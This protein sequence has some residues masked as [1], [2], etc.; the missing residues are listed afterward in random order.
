[1]NSETALNLQYCLVVVQ[2][3]P[4]GN[5]NLDISA[6]SVFDSC[7]NEITT[8]NA[9]TNQTS[10]CILSEHVRKHSNQNNNML[11]Q[12]MPPLKAKFVQKF[13]NVNFP[14]GVTTCFKRD[15]LIVCD[16]GKDLIKIFDNTAKLLR[17]FQNSNYNDKEKRFFLR[18]PSALLID[19]EN[20][21]LLF[22]KDDTYQCITIG[23]PKLH[24]GFLFSRIQDPNIG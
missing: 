7:L 1:M 10:I 20:D 19:Y 24:F 17:T 16:C 14:I 12:S 9:N 18:R 23:R 15:W 13:S 11:S 3:G 22:V 5:P 4:N 6:R 2:I 8:D 21:D